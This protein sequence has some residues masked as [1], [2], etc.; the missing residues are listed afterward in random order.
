MSHAELAGQLEPRGFD[1]ASLF[2]N[3]ADL[4]EA[5]LITRTD[6]GDHMWRFHVGRPG[7]P[8]SPHP[9]FICVACGKALCLDGVELTV[10]T[11]TGAPRA[12]EER[13]AEINFRGRCD[14]C[15]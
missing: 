5:G 14:E 6:L 15:Y 8:R 9:H 2:R 12:L 3:L 4:T 1:R 10:R 11:R 13:K 7:E